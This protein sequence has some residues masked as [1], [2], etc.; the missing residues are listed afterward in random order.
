MKKKIILN[1]I[2]SMLLNYVTYFDLEDV[3]FSLISKIM[4][5][6]RKGNYRIVSC[7]KNNLR[8]HYYTHSSDTRLNN[9]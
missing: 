5:F 4:N 3:E 1:I 9:T 7:I 8:T 2:R 6:L